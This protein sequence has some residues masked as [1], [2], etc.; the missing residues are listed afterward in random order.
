MKMKFRLIFVLL[1]C[2]FW[3]V[4]A[5]SYTINVSGGNQSLF[6]FTGTD[7]RNFDCDTV[8]PAKNT[9]YF[10]NIVA[11]YPFDCSGNGFSGQNN[12]TIYGAVYVAGKYGNALSFDGGDDY[13]DC[14]N[15]GIGGV[16][17]KE[18]WFK[19]NN[20]AGSLN[21][22]FL[23]FGGNNYWVQ[24]YDHD[25]DG[26]LEIRAGAGSM[27]YLNSIYEFTDT[28][29][30]YHIAV[31]MDSSNVLTIYV[32]GN[33]DNSGSRTPE[34]PGTF[35]IGRYGGGGYYFN[36]LIDEV[37]IY[38]RALTAGEVLNNYY[39]GRSAHFK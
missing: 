29:Q 17:T 6:D 25:G 2:L 5:N 30:W 15:L 36:G 18:F 12:G 23:D 3:S 24:I 35:S 28:S 9:T 20:L 7:V 33:Y 39:A 31:T 27:T 32:N 38:S 10:D 14:G 13:V 37:R 26:K 16:N 8:A 11:Y 19:P 21:Q 22:Y 1:L 34:T 4:Q